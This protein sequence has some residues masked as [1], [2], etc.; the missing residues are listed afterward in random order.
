[1]DSP[2]SNIP[3][4]EEEIEPLVKKIQS[5]VRG[6]ETRKKYL[7]QKKAATDIQ[8]R[9]RGNISR[10]IKRDDPMRS[11]VYRDTDW[12]TIDRPM[13]WQFEHD[14]I[15]RSIYGDH[16]IDNIEELD[17]LNTKYNEQNRLMKKKSDLIKKLKMDKEYLEESEVAK[18]HGIDGKSHADLPYTY[19]GDL[20][21]GDLDMEETQQKIDNYYRK[22]KRINELE[23]YYKEDDVELLKNIEEDIALYTKFKHKDE[24]IDIFKCMRIKEFGVADPRLV[25]TE[26]FKKIASPCKDLTEIY[27]NTLYSIP[28][29]A[30]NPTRDK[31]QKILDVT[32]FMS[33]YGPFRKSHVTALNDTLMDLRLLTPYDVTKLEDNGDFPFNSF[34]LLSL[35]FRFA[36]KRSDVY[37]HEYGFHISPWRRSEAYGRG[38]GIGGE[39]VLRNTL[40]LFEATIIERRLKYHDDKNG[41]ENLKRYFI[42]CLIGITPYN[43]YNYLTKLLNTLFILSNAISAELTEMDMEIRQTAP[44]AGGWPHPRRKG[45]TLLMQATSIYNKR[46]Y[47]TPALYAQV[48]PRYKKLL[49]LNFKYN[50]ILRIY[51]TLYTM[52]NNKYDGNGEPDL[53][54]IMVKF[55]VPSLFKVPV[56]KMDSIWLTLN[57][58]IKDLYRGA[59]MQVV[60][61][62]RLEEF[63]KREMRSR[64]DAIPAKT[65][66]R[67]KK[68]RK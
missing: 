37:L 23:E 38:R 52:Y 15:E 53:K 63:N 12:K 64:L 30:I 20:E 41:I 45:T 2:R 31:E 4:K 35:Y 68:K 6:R 28:W 50:N 16:Y 32:E 7:T 33:H 54:I 59:T 26:N 14:I 10:R 42:S 5:L 13:P 34:R 44:G 66:K 47:S 27:I 11:I 8:S 24:E 56:D 60:A 61:N 55:P 18:E 19:Y 58:I 67:S 39:E 57:Q 29:E 43:I 22:Y 9:V 51:E 3:L 48:V 1:M 46:I 25:L 36:N 49:E 40:E 65:T 17:R 21:E 62:Y